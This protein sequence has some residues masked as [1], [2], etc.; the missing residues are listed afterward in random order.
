MNCAGYY[1][2]FSKYAALK[3]SVA[4]HLSSYFLCPAGIVIKHKAR[5]IGGTTECSI[6]LLLPT[7]WSAS[8]ILDCIFV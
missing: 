1:E 3:I 7:K 5:F 2:K 8:I 6:V 4:E